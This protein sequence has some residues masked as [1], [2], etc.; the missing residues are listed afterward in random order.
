MQQKAHHLQLLPVEGDVEPLDVAQLLRRGW[1]LALLAGNADTLLLGRLVAFHLEHR[2]VLQHQLGQRQ[3]QRLG[4]HRGGRR[5]RH[6]TPQR[7]HGGCRGRRVLDVLLRD[8]P[9]RKDDVHRVARLDEITHHIRRDRQDKERLPLVERRRQVAHLGVRGAVH[10][11]LRLG[12]R[13][14]G[15]HRL[16]QQRPLVLVQELVGRDVLIQ[17]LA[18]DPLPLFQV[19]VGRVQHGPGRQVLEG[20]RDLVPR[21]VE[22]PPGKEQGHD[23]RNR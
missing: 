13:K 20:D 4:D 11:Q 15:A 2:D 17:R 5:R 21:R 9:D 3:T 8:R 22:Q 19:K 10:Q 23:D 16:Q 6:Q 12:H 1:G 18:A 14:A 7:R